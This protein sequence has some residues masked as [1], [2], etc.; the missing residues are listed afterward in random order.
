M[1]SHGL[2]DTRGIPGRQRRAEGRKTRLAHE[3]SHY[4]NDA[5]ESEQKVPSRD[6]EHRQTQ[7]VVALEDDSSES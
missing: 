7:I 3:G 6:P 1:E 5:V 2:R 4:G